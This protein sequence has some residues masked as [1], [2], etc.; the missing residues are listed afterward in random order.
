MHEKYSLLP[1]N[2]INHVVPQEVPQKFVIKPANPIF[3]AEIAKI[4]RTKISFFFRMAIKI[5]EQKK[6]FVSKM[7]F[8]RAV[9]MFFE[10]KYFLTEKYYPYNSIK[11]V[12]PGGEI[13]TKYLVPKS[14]FL[15]EL[16]TSPKFTFFFCY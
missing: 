16:F 10:Q 13:C 9:R 6:F 15:C 7:H 5:F 4:F 2:T 11:H 8:F 14:H 12:V 1:Y 3:G